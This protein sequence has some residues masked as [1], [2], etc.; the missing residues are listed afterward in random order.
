M[1]HNRTSKALLC[2]ILLFVLAIPAGIVSASSKNIANAQS[3]F[4]KYGP[5]N[6]SSVQST[7]TVT[8]VW[9]SSSGATGYQYCYDTVNNSSCDN[10]WYSTSSTMATVS[11][12][13][14]NTYYWQVRAT[15]PGGSV[16]AT[17]GW[18]SFNATTPPPPTPTP[19]PFG[20]STPTNGA[21]NQ[22]PTLLTAWSSSPNA[23]RYEYC[24]D[25]SNN[26]NCDNASGWVNNGT[27]QWV[28]YYGLS[29]NTTY[30]WQVRA[31]DASNNIAYAN[32]YTWWSF[33]V[34]PPTPTPTVTPIPPSFVK[35]GPSNGSSVMSSTIVWGSSYGATQ[36]QYCYDTTNNNSCDTSWNSAGTNTYANLSISPN[37]FY[38]WQVRSINGSGVT[39]YADGSATSWWSFKMVPTPTPTPTTAPFGKSN[40]ANGGT[41]H[42]GT[43]PLA[44]SAAGGATS[45]EYCLDT[46]NNG[47]CDTTWIP[48][49][50]N[51]YVF[52]SGQTIGITYSW[53]VRAVVGGSYVYANSGSWWSFLTN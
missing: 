2:L 40:P 12:Y 53:Q 50:T 19:V 22:S 48:T 35:Y 10:G 45:Y 6:G 27:Q 9:G 51:Q 28:Y 24:Y 17:G 13:V 32:N 30:Y 37:I 36:Y 7:G 44:W 42:P 11:V 18:W 5:S 3:S 39:T 38:Y 29:L 1:L 49:G 26:N 16:D 47:S 8:I 23:V 4:V 14:G 34:M 25:T 20:K 46:I 52:V 33:T 41:W 21:T 31:V 43:S 15:G